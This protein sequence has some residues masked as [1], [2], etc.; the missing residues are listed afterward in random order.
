[1]QKFMIEV[2]NEVEA[3][4]AL[5][6]RQIDGLVATLYE[7][8]KP[9]FGLSGFL[10][11]RF[12]G[13]IS[14]CLRSGVLTGQVGE[15]VYFPV[16]KNGQV[17]KLIL[18]GAGKSNVPGQRTPPPAETLKALTKNLEGLK[19]TSVGVSRRDF[20]NPSEEFL[21][22]NLRGISLRVTL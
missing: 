5:I 19:L 15:C 8:E 3:D 18:A 22:K 7:N 9:L 10:D 11:W 2:L 21:N 17:Y 1:M 14:E 20:G 4:Q 13:A 12:H 6:N 16:S